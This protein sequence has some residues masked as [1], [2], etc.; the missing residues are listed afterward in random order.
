[1]THTSNILILSLLLVAAIVS[2]EKEPDREDSA[3]QGTRLFQ[4]ERLSKTTIIL[5]GQ[6]F[7]VELAVTRAARTRGLMFRRGLA[8]D[9]G[10]LF[11]FEKERPRGFY[12]KNCLIDLDVVFIT[13]EGEIARLTTMRTPVPGK[14]LKTYESGIPVKYVLE[15]PAG[16]AR[17]IG[18]QP[19][20]TIDLPARIRNII[21]EP[22]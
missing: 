13:A 21:P 22:L 16:T 7:S 4:P 12:M 5:A 2:C 17:R 8:A 20:Q 18:L 11:V 10:M 3:E 6:S 14:P 15:L 9:A 19:D 1:M